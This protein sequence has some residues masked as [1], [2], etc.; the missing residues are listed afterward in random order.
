MTAA[1][2]YL[3]Y[4]VKLAA[5][6]ATGCAVTWALAEF[7]TTVFFNVVDWTS[8]VTLMVMIVVGGAVGGGVSAGTAFWLVKR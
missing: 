6:I 3:M 8:P 1:K 7:V 2:E 4:G 5:A